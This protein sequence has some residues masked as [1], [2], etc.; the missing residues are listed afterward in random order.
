MTL[1]VN[2]FVGGARGVIH[3][4]TANI[5]RCAIKRHS[6][7]YAEKVINPTFLTKHTVNNMRECN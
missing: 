4:H 5:N 7:H 2:A 3:I 6:C 1:F